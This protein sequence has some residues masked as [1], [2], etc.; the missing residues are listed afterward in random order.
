M[1]TRTVYRLIYWP[2]IQGRGE[3]VRLALEEAGATY[4]DVARLPADKGGGEAAILKYT[5]GRHAGLRPFAAPILVYGRTV[6]SQ[7]ANILSFLGPRLGLTPRDTTG[8]CAVN[9]IQLTIADFVTEIHDTHH[10]I[11]GSLYYKDQKPAARRRAEL[12]R[13][14]RLPKFLRYFEDL[15]AHNKRR[16]AQHLVGTQLTYADLS[17]FQVMTGLAY[18]FPNALA[19]LVPEIPRVCALRDQVAARPRI[20]AYLIS[21]RRISNNEDDIFRKY[22]ELDAAAK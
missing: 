9:Q 21:D 3:F 17:L 12:F 14:E 2:T 22:P 4:V 8:R 19:K 16:R 5:Q 7:V 1:P 11:A 20:A 18:A 15:L 13:A 10:P 6:L